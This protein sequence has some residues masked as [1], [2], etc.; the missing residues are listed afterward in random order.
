[1]PRLRERGEECARSRVQYLATT[2]SKGKLVREA[3]LGESAKN[4]CLWPNGAAYSIVPSFRSLTRNAQQPRI[5]VCTVRPSLVVPPEK[6]SAKGL[7]T[8]AVR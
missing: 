2:V 7:E 1:M 3:T 4:S 8:V 5:K 6:A